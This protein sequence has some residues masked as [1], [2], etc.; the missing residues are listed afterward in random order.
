MEVYMTNR[1]KILIG[2]LVVIIVAGIIVT[3]I[4][5][6]NK[7]TEYKDMKQVDFYLGTD[8]NIEDVRNITNDVF[9]NQK[10]ILKKVEYFNDRISIST[11]NISEEQLSNLVK[12]INEVY[13]LDNTED[14]VD[15]VTIPGLN[16]ID[17][18]IPYIAPILI[19]LAIILVYIAIRFKKLGVIKVIFT[20]LFWVALVIDICYSVIAII[21]IPI[22]IYAMPIAVGIMLGTLT[23]VIYKYEK[24]ALSKV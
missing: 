15:I 23:V 20:S 9:G 22:N 5:G 24:K 8:V 1:E 18:V 10:V 16:I 19:S 14:S 2:L 13:N 12:E 11:E 21:R 3:A 17:T 7:G 6:I 4:F